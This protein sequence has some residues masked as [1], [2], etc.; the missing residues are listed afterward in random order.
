MTLH[1]AT[2]SPGCGCDRQDMLHALISIDEALAGY[3]Q[4]IE[5]IIQPPFRI[6]PLSCQNCSRS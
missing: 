3:C 4:K 1:Q 6:H 2:L 5:V